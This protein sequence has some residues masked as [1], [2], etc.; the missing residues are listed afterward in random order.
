MAEDE[1]QLYGSPVA[2]PS[3]GPSTLLLSEIMYEAAR[4][5]PQ[6]S[7]SSGSLSPARSKPNAKT[8]V[9]ERNSDCHEKQQRNYLESKK[10]PKLEQESRRLRRNEQE[11]HRSQQLSLQFEDLQAVLTDAGVVVP[12]GTKGCVLEAAQSYIQFL[13][14]RCGAAV[15]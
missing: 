1:E 11:Q 3:A 9:E 7:L 5:D 10:K 8:S 12:R 15:Q 14:Q 4:T 2:A 13:Q 6:S